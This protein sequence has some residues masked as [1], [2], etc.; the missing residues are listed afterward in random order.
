MCPVCWSARGSR[1]VRSAVPRALPMIPDSPDNSALRSA[2][3]SVNILHDSATEAS[4]SAR[5]MMYVCVLCRSCTC[6]DAAPRALEC[7]HGRV[8]C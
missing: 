7:V 1:S 8:L 6:W 5:S 2:R 4:D 3:A